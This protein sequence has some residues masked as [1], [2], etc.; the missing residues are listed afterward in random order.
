MGRSWKARVI[1]LELGAQRLNTQ[2]YVPTLSSALLFR[3]VSVAGICRQSGRIGR[4]RPHS[5]AGVP[6]SSS[7]SGRERAGRLERQKIARRNRRDNI[8]AVKV[9]RET[10]SRVSVV[11]RLWSWHGGRARATKD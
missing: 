2:G 8:V 10:N 3:F 11:E 9:Q 6:V 5:M 4:A 1:L 7:P